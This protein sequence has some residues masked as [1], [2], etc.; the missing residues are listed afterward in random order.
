VLRFGI[1]PPDCRRPGRVLERRRGGG[2][3]IVR[4]VHI[5]E[6]LLKGASTVQGVNASVVLLSLIERTEALTVIDVHTQNVGKSNLEETVF[7]SA[8][9]EAA[10]EVARQLRL[11]RTR[12]ESS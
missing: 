2:L 3:P 1:H 11:A 6:Q 7:P 9:P 10:E 8:Q 12:R 4:A 5:S